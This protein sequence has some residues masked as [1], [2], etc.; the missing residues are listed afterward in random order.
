M[1]PL[2]FTIAME[3]LT[4]IHMVMC[5]HRDFKFHSLCRQMKLTHLC[6]ADDLLMF[7]RGDCQSVSLLLSAFETFS[8]ASG[9]T[10]NK[11]KSQLFFNGTSLKTGNQLQLLTGMP[12]GSLPFKYLGVP[13]SSRKL[14]V[15]DC[16]VL[17]EKAVSQ[18][19]AWGARKLSYAGRLVLVKA[20]LTHLHS[21]WASIFLIPAGVLKRI[22]QICRNY[23]WEGQGHYSHSPNVAWEEVCKPIKAGGLGILNSKLMNKALIGKYVWWIAQKE[24]KLWIRWVHGTYLKSQNWWEY[25]PTINSSWV[26]R[27]VCK[28]RDELRNG[29]VGSNWLSA[30]G[31]YSVATG[32][33]WLLGTLRQA[34]WWP[35]IWNRMAVPKHSFIGWLSV[36][37]RLATRDRLSRWGACL[38]SSC[39]LCG[40]GIEDHQHL[41][42]LCPFSS[43]CCT[44]LAAQLQM[45]IQSVDMCNWWVTKR[46]QSLMVK[47]VVGAAILGL[48]YII[49]WVRNQARLHATIMHP[50]VAVHVVLQQIKAR[51]RSFKHT[52]LSPRGRAWLISCNL[53]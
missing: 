45:P 12:Q 29:Y 5:D 24:D 49:W 47:Q 44:R 40:Q 15:M 16:E 9:L 33:S 42:F 3:Y 6:F 25:E 1:S 41:F 18:I 28:T 21:Y 53:I 11:A 46:F 36:Q 23:L 32:Y 27:M 43:I 31:S 19:R 22:N 2:L 52:T 35:L 14:A 34:P 38:D 7:C 37:H 26:W 50:Q 4:R 48:M 20:V 17:I 51:L 10:M 39:F 13:I 30:Q 8:L